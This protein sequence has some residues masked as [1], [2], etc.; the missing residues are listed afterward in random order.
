MTFTLTPSA[1]ARVIAGRPASVA[2]ILTSRL[3]RSTVFHRSSAWATVASVSWASRGSTSSDTRPSTPPVVSQVPLNTSQACWT[4]A[5]VISRT[6]SSTDGAAGGELADLLVVGLAVRPARAA[7][8]V[9]LVVT[10]TTCLSVISSCRLPLRQPLAG[11]V[12]E[13]DGHAGRGELRP[14][15]SL[16]MWLLLLR[17]SLRMLGQAALRGG[18]HVLRGEAE[19]AEQRLVVGAGAE[20]LDGDDLAR[21]ADEPVP[22]LRD[23]GLDADPGPAPPAGSTD[24]R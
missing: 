5:T 7:K 17:R 3:G 8:I 14:S 24:S 10:P 11:Q 18:D 21:V 2:G 22:R 9:G 20:V 4:S 1:S 15:R 23:A 6:A 13:P 16:L 12:V 19:L